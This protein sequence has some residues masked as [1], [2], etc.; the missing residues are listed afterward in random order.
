[1]RELNCCHALLENNVFPALNNLDFVTEIESRTNFDQQVE[2]TL[3]DAACYLDIRG[4]PHTQRKTGKPSRTKPTESQPAN[5]EG[6][7]KRGF[8]QITRLLNLLRRNCILLEF[9]LRQHN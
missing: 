5:G 7:P 3:H 1:M 6:E 8:S 4:R 2:P 9:I